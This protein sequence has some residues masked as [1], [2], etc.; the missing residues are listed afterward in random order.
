MN[1]LARNITVW[2]KDREWAEEVFYDVL[3]HV[4]FK[5]FIA[6]ARAS[7]SDLIIALK[8]GTYF[9]LVPITN[10]SSKGMKSHEI[11]VQDGAIDLETYDRLI[12]PMVLWPYN[13]IV[14]ISKASDMLFGGKI[15]KR[16]DLIKQEEGC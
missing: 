2:Y 4:P 15:L 1:Y 14:A 3:N 7:R 5:E 12:V 9:R 6:A 13:N 10:N 16:S 8:D 11:Y